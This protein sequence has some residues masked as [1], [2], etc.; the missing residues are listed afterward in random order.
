MRRL[1]SRWWPWLLA[2]GSV[3]LAAL[4]VGP[5]RIGG[6]PLDPRST[7]PDGARAVLDVLAE[8]GR[9]VAV[10]TRP[11]PGTATFVVLADRLDRA[12]RDAALRWV[13]DGGRLV[14]ADPGS[15]LLADVDLTGRLPTDVLGPTAFA[16][17]C[18][19]PELRDVDLVRSA[20]WFAFSERAGDRTCFPVEG[21]AW[22][23]RRPVGGGEL[24]ALGG[25]DAFTNA[26]LGEADNAL[27]LVRLL[28]DAGPVVVAGAAPPGGGDASLGELVPDRIH[29]ALALLALAFVV[30]A[31]ARGRRL[32]DPV[33]EVLPV[34]IPASELVLAT[35]D[36]MRRAGV[37]D[38]A[39]ES[40]RGDLRREAATRFGLPDDAPPDVV[41]DRIATWTG[42]DPAGVAVA[43]GRGSVPDDDTLVG[44][45]RA[46]ARLRERLRHGPLA[47]P[48]DGE[49]PRTGT[50][51]G[52]GRGR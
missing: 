37:R 48:G 13:S 25:A 3:L 16:P 9:P 29:L 43:V 44:I 4:V 47:S 24:V 21:G 28:G 11:D 32:G 36:L 33:E 12:S 6:E 41:A 42:S 8:L 40:L 27:L 7:A 23:L 19:D 20:T 14:V 38:A 45:A 39:A 46:V 35:A 49:P 1:L 15:A 2:V 22:L 30:A 31:W 5:P 52:E 18:E 26:R 50:D 34:R 10:A 17:A 51:P